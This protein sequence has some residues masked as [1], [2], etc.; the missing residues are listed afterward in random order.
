MYFFKNVHFLH[1]VF[2]WYSLLYSK[3]SLN[4]YGPPQVK[5]WLFNSAPFLIQLISSIFRKCC[6]IISIFPKKCWKFIASKMIEIN[7]WHLT[8]GD[9]FHIFFPW[10]FSV[11]TYTCTYLCKIYTK[12]PAA[13]VFF[14]DHG[15]QKANKSKI[16]I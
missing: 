11:L 9:Q 6:N 7:T 3:D 12:Q 16:P 8:W 2:L 4:Y 15:F 10:V 5:F 1:I 13:R 14:R